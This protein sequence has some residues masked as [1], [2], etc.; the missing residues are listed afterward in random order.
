MRVV[1]VAEKR[2]DRKCLQQLL[3]DEQDLEVVGEAG[4]GWLAIPVVCKTRPDVL[5]MLLPVAHAITATRLLAAECPSTRVIGVSMSETDDPTTL[6]EAGA[7]AYLP[8]SES[9]DVLIAAI[10]DCTA[11]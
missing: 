6:L 10:R 3:G 11:E 7:V 1:V 5:L 2:S 4:D 9:A 8:D